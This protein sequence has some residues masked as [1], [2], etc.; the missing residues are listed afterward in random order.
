MSTKS[1]GKTLNDKLKKSKLEFDGLI[2]TPIDTEYVTENW[3][4]FMNTQYKWK[5]PKEQ[6]IDFYV[7]NTGRTIKLKGQVKDYRVVELYVLSRGNL[8]PFNFEDSSEGLVDAQY[9]V[10]DGTMAEFDFLINIGNLC[11]IV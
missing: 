2:F 9:I 4:K 3:N 6:T 8:A 5:P 7:K 1:D 11:L 10:K